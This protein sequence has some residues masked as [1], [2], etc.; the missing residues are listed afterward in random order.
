MKEL[1]ASKCFFFS[2]F[3]MVQKLLW[4]YVCAYEVRGQPQFISGD[5]GSLTGNWGSLIRLGR[6]A[7][8]PVNLEIC[9]SSQY[10]DYKNVSPYQAF[11]VDWTQVLMHWV[12][13]ASKQPF[14]L[15]S[16]IFSVAELAQFN[17]EQRLDLLQMA[18]TGG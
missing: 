4:M 1:D 14:Q 13:S 3:S 11:D 17:P 15:F 6:V 12:T 18:K 2:S 8:E 16:N 10:W 5:L 7:G 9:L